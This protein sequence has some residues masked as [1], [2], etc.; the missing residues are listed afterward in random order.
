MSRVLDWSN[1]GWTFMVVASTGYIVVALS[2]GALES[3]YGR[4]VLGA[5]GCCWMGDMVG[6]HHFVLGT[7]AFL[8]GHLLFVPAF[9][10]E[11]LAWR[12]AAR[13][14]LAV[15]V[16]SAAALLRL[17]PDIPA[18]ERG[19]MVA[20]TAV[21]SV[22]VAAAY[23]AGR[24]GQI[25]PAAATI[26][27]VSDLFVGNWKYGGGAWNGLVCYPLYYAACLLFAYSIATTATARRAPGEA[28]GAQ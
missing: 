15:S 12:P 28:A 18:G 7:Y 21:I 19:A 26:F 6:P 5:L 17:F 14:G 9:C 1:L 10:L 23:G 2:A 4:L 20:Y 8:A 27:Y 24:L 13:A 22:M 25:V 11:R 3:R 16:V